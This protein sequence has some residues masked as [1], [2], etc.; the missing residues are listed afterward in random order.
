MEMTVVAFDFDE[1]LTVRDTVVPFMRKVAGRAS[2]VGICVRN[3][4]EIVGLLR[5]RDRDSVKEL[6]VSEVFTGKEVD[7]VE[8]VGHMYAMK[9][10]GRY[11][12]SDTMERLRWHQ[13]QGH[14]VVLVSASLSPYLHAV[15]DL[16]EVDAVLCTELQQENGMYNGFLDGSNCRGQEKVKRMQ[17]W[18]IEAGCGDQDLQF[19]YGDSGGDD[20]LLIFSLNG[21]N[22]RRK[23]L[24]RAIR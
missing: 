19:A 22:V 1:T 6:F 16:L 23:E 7:L 9:V 12:R 24:S 21:T 10:V 11:M 18:M 15:G 3:F 17:A 14:V 20:A 8:H 5:R 13:E 4:I 2:F